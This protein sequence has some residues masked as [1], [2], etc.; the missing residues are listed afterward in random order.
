M[1]KKINL[2]QAVGLYA[3][4]INLDYKHAYL[5]AYLVTFKVLHAGNSPPLYLYYVD[6]SRRIL[7]D[8]LVVGFSL[9]CYSYHSVWFSVYQG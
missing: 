5:H 3:S 1:H 9:H 6:K 2:F 4:K 8:I 7:A